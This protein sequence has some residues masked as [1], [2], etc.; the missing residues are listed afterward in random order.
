MTHDK[1]DAVSQQHTSNQMLSHR[2]GIKSLYLIENRDARPQHSV[3]G[4][5]CRL[6]ANQ[7]IVGYECM[8]H[9]VDMVQHGCSLS[10]AVHSHN[11]GIWGN[12]GAHSLAGSSSH[13]KR[14]LSAEGDYPLL[15]G[16]YD[17]A[18]PKHWTTLVVPC[19]VG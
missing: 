10:T 5:G 13:T 11:C 7:T 12:M 16:V 14:I 8:S 15:Q 4:T 9:G 1:Q 3:I 19:S 2:A 6:D 17:E 18:R